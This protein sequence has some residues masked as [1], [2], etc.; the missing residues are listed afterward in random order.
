MTVLWL[1]LFF[2][3]GAAIGSFINVVA[4]R[5]PEG[6]SIVSPPSHCSE[7]QQQISA[8]DNIPIISYLWLRGRCRNCGA[9]I[10]QRLLWVELGAAILFAFLYWHYGLGWE[11]A[12][13]ALYC[14]L[15]ISLL[16]IDV[17]HGILPD[18]IVYPGVIIALVVAALGS[19]FGFE[20]SDIVGWGFRLWIVDAAIGG[21][22][23]FLLLL[24]PAL[25][26]RGGMGWGDIKLAAL[27]GF[28]TGF[29]L[30]LL[31]MFLA[32]IIGGL[33]A[34]ILLLL[35]LKGRKDAIPFGPFL[36]LAAM[37]TLFW[38]S[39][40]LNWLIPILNPK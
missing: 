30:V 3:V 15:F 31:A 4:D 20:P 37:V 13:V 17:E 1:V 14:C 5:L 35:K 24:L 27:I 34:A 25:I 12:L 6:K 29:P 39:D 38:G 7:C 26:Y 21:G 23:G 28:I 10:P 8:S 22:I 11:L 18:K 2:M 9:T 40:I 16:L 32:V 19:I 33:I 36:S